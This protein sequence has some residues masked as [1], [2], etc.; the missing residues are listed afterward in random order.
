MR[1]IKIL[2]LLFLL[3]GC[4]GSN[5]HTEYKCKDGIIYIKS[6]G[7]WIQA[8]IYEKNKCLPE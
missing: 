5:F 6:S 1:I 3:L 2:P 8:M 4:D 7:A